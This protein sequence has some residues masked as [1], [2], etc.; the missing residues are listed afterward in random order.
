MQVVV[1][2]PAFSISHD[3]TLRCLHVTWRGP[4]SASFIRAYCTEVL[5]QVG[6]T[7]STR[8]LNDGLLDLDGWQQAVQWIRQVT[9]PQLAAQGVVAIAWVLPHDLRAQT[10][11]QQAIAHLPRPLMD[12]FRDVES[13]YAWL[14]RI[15]APPATGSQ[16]APPRQ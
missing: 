9:F 7:A 6:R 15:P 5:V 12:T 3:A 13:A 10:H 14:Q 8:I 11:V 16:A 2:S 4:H 1:D